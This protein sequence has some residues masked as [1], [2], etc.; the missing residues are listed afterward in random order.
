MTEHAH[1]DA[2]AQFR[3]LI[4]EFL[5]AAAP[6]V[7][8]V[9]NTKAYGEMLGQTLANLVALNRINSDVMDLAWRNLRIASRADIVS[10]HRQLA[11]TEDKLEMVLE[12]VERLEEEVAALR[13]KDTDAAPKRRPATSRE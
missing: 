11:R 5:A 10:L 8:D 3:K 2:S 7:E 6:P 13:R 12:A 9:V 1:A 4:D